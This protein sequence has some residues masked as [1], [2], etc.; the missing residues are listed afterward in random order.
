M[1]TLNVGQSLELTKLI[2]N[3]KGNNYESY[4]PLFFISVLT[5]TVTVSLLCSIFHHLVQTLFEI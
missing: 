5:L 4:N 3:P 1:E 2:S